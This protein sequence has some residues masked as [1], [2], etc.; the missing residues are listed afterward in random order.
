MRKMIDKVKKF[1]QFVN[2]KNENKTDRANIKQELFFVSNTYKN[3]D[4]IIK[5]TELKPFNHNTVDK[6]FL[7]SNSVVFYSKGIPISEINNINMDSNEELVT[8][9]ENRLNDLVL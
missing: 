4:G 6:I 8:L 9:I 1:K 2:E 5:Y 3:D 7:Y